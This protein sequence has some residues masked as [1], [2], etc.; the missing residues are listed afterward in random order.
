MRVRM[1]D[2]ARDLA[3]S[4]VTVSKVLR[5]VP[6]I[7]EETRRRVLRRME[8]LD[9]RPDRA[10]QS[11]ATGRTAMRGLIV[12]DLVHPFFAQVAKRASRIF[13]EQGYGLVIA[14]S[15]QDVSLEK[16]EIGHML[17]R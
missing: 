5:N 14:S 2:I 13:R 10:A 3:V 8:E 4:V 9:Y 6:E 17:S 7:G 15:E 11:L 16:K 12:P 1:K